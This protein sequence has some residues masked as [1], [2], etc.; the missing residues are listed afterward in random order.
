M[1]GEVRSLVLV[2]KCEEFIGVGGWQV[3]RS[4]L[5]QK[6]LQLM[7]KI[8]VL[9]IISVTMSGESARTTT[10]IKGEDRQRKE[11]IG[12]S[13]NLAFHPQPAAFFRAQG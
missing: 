7:V 3:W 6:V 9:M 4:E 12:L 8:L 5:L 10:V 2:A 11:Y 13:P 1:A